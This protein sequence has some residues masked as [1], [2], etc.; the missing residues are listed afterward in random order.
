MVEAA[1]LHAHQDVPGADRRIRDFFDFEDFRA[2]VPFK[3][4]YPHLEPPR[5]VPAIKP[6]KTVI[7]TRAN[8]N[9]GRLAQ[10]LPHHGLRYTTPVRSCNT[11]E[12]WASGM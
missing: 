7:P 9:Q 10:L 3:D 5:R 12:C 4:G 8:H 2:A 1:G 6:V 11:K